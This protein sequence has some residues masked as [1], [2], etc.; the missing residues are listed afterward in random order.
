[1]NGC[2]YIHE[3]IDIIG[4]QRAN[5][6]HHITANW[7]PIGQEERAQK[8][9]G[10]FAVLGSTGRWPQVC[11]LW[12]HDSWAGMA[13]SFEIETVGAGAQDPALVTW[14]GA[15]AQF[16]SGGLDRLMRPAPWTRTIDELCAQ[17]I[18]AQCYAH[19][20]IRV[21]PGADR[22]YLDRIHD[23][24]ERRTPPGFELIG[25]FSTAMAADD[26]VMLLWAVRTW[27][28]WAAA[29]QA[30]TDGTDVT[31]QPGDRQLVVARQ[32]IL[33]V[34]AP[35]SPLRTHRQPSRADRTDWVE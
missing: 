17:Q 33:L 22:E 19:D 5:Y 20:L 13:R 4:H 23:Q 34:D 9:F 26:E 32:R 24:L 25:A 2:A 35:L 7:S 30:V 14:W 16:R 18:N 6:L 21:R 31:W 3:F 1:M 8:C 10:V 27:Q 29:E 11:N 12:E 28:D 15:A